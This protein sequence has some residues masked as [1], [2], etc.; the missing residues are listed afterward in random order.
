VNVQFPIIC[1]ITSGQG[2]VPG[3][4]REAASSGI[5]LV[6]IRE[7][8]L[9]GGA[10]LSFVRAAIDEAAQ[11]SC[12]VLVNDRFDVAIAANAAG[13]HLRGNSFP[14]GRIRSLAPTGFLIG[15]SVHSPAQAAAVTH[16]GGCDYLIFGTVF[17]SRNKPQGHPVAGLKVL[18][19]VCRTTILPVIAVGGISVENAAEVVAAGA[20]GVAGI[21]MF[22][23]SLS[24]TVS[25]L[26]QR[27][28]T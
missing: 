21:D 20:K 5:D 27:F 9:E 7:P 16:D 19:E 11:T 12:R 2:T 3:L 4:V 10:L 18:R 8:G 25:V 17:Q 6:Q 13:V 22:R 26:R 14:A 28:D 15:R 1:L 24:S 23:G